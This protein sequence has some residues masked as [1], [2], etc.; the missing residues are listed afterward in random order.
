MKK[1]LLLFSLLFF[2]AGLSAQTITITNAVEG[3]YEANQ[4]INV[5][6][7]TNNLPV[8]PTTIQH[9]PW[10]TTNYVT[11]TIIAS[12]S[13]ANFLI[14][15]TGTYKIRI[16]RSGASDTS[17]TVSIWPD[18]PDR[19]DFI[20][21]ASGEQLQRGTYD[22]ITYYQNFMSIAQGVD[23]IDSSN[24]VIGV[25][26]VSYVSGSTNNIKR[27]R[28]YVT[29]AACPGCRIAL[30][31]NS[32]MTG[33]DFYDTSGTC[34]MNIRSIAGKVF[35]D[36]NENTVFDGN[37]EPYS[38]P[39]VEP[40]NPAIPYTATSD[41]MGNY[42]LYVDYSGLLA[43]KVNA[44][45]ACGSVALP[46]Q[47]TV[48][49]PVGTATITGRNFR[50]VPPTGIPP[51]PEVKI[52]P[53]FTA[54]PHPAMRTVIVRN[55]GGTPTAAGTLTYTFPQGDE[56]YAPWYSAGTPAI[57]TTPNT[58][59]FAVP[60]LNPCEERPLTLYL[61]ATCPTNTIL[62]EIAT[63]T[64]GGF[65]HKDTSFVIVHGSYDPNDKNVDRDTI[66]APQL[67]VAEELYYMIRFQNTGELA[68]FNIHVVDTLAG[69][70]NMAT[71]RTLSAS[72]SFNLTMHNSN[73]AQWRFNNI[74]LPDSTSDEPGSH[75]YIVFSI[76]PKN[77]LAVGDVINNFADI[78]F[79][80]NE[81]VRTNTAV[82]RILNPTGINTEKEGV[83][84]LYPNP[85]SGFVQVNMKD[86][87]NG[88]ATVKLYTTDGKVLQ[89][90]TH[91]LQNSTILMQD[92]SGLSNGVYHIGI[93]V[94]G[95]ETVKK[96]VVIH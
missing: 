6:W 37:D 22:T 33:T 57:A 42:T 25:S 70:F 68:A 5:T 43:Y 90:A 29:N 92:I 71:F 67:P 10:G 58:I 1:F 85:A 86:K 26:A 41:A 32:F 75:G 81:P 11:D 44:N 47:D 72:H 79:D 64:S 48:T 62:Q 28:I 8:G 36:Y 82:V 65:T 96:L 51:V 59:T 7:N 63:F 50:V 40:V 35:Y 60:P 78:Y 45:L 38:N 54:I 21:H 94:D 19:I 30:N 24:N 14:P 27:G 61:Q 93:T 84:S 9:A 52:I 39:I 73:I 2:L 31:I 76:L 87:L 46:V 77:T 16:S 4:T 88:K 74:M 17:G 95:K 49:L 20:S 55:T 12:G 56:N 23:F 83:Y 13:T 80:Y 34:D 91:Y 3:I 89:T 53:E 15:T 18:L 66:Y 69:A